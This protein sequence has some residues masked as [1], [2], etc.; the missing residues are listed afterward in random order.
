MSPFLGDTDEETLANVSSAEFEFHDESWDFVS[1]KAKD[2]ICRL[3]VKDKRYYCSFDIL[4]TLEKL[5]NL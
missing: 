1:D 3:M 4:I 2:F 5:N